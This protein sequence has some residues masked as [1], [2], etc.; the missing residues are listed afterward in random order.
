MAITLKQAFALNGTPDLDSFNDLQEQ[1]K[2]TSY[3]SDS[4]PIN[5][6]SS[7]EG[8][9]YGAGYDLSISLSSTSV[10]AT[11][12]TITVTYTIKE[13]RSNGDVLVSGVKPAVTSTLGTV[14][15]IT[16]TNTS[17]V[18]TATITIDNNKSLSSKS[19][20]VTVSSTLGGSLISK[21]STAT[22]ATGYYTYGSITINTFTYGAVGAAGGTSSPSI[23]YS[24]PYGWNG[25]TSGAGTINGNGDDD[26]TTYKETGGHSA[27]TVNSST[28]VVTWASN[29]QSTSSRSVG[30]TATVTLNGKSNTKA[31]TSTQNAD[32]YTD[33]TVYQ[34]SA[35]SLSSATVTAAAGSVTVSTTV[36]KR[37]ARK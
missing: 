30:I 36:Q 24:Q 26:Y 35:L 4:K 9:W 19:I 3:F 12:G 11:G 29:A 23:T 25:S 28:G 16:T 33:S 10:A 6:L 34:V 5:H 27:A 21:E 17:G 31:A 7:W 2:N 22:Q 15:N 20:K 32:T 18:G 13:H 14:S 8:Y 1:C 37:T